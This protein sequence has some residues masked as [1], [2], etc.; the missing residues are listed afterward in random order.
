MAANFINQSID[1]FPS[2]YLWLLYYRYLNHFL[3]TSVC[4]YTQANLL[5][6]TQWHYQAESYDRL[7]LHN[8]Y[9]ID[10]LIAEELQEIFHV[11][12]LESDKQA[13]KNLCLLVKLLPKVGAI[14]RIVAFIFPFTHIRIKYKIL[15]ISRF[16]LKRTL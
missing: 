1:I 10:L 14:F 6:K 2:D 11:D 9:H 7:L 13:N 12:D 15:I 4:L 8:L 3:V 16:F 5:N